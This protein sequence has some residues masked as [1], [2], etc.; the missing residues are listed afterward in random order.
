MSFW[1]RGPAMPVDHAACE[2]TIRVLEEVI[3]DLRRQNRELHE[4][5]VAMVGLG[6]EEHA[7]A[8]AQR[9]AIRDAENRRVKVAADQ[10][11]RNP[12]AEPT[13]ETVLHRGNRTES[14]PL[15]EFPPAVLK[16]V[17]NS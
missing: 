3:A 14:I 2:R 1:R 8:L 11:E 17:V 16:S 4:R 12:E 6:Y 5:S 13:L 9:N 7:R 15:E 10:M